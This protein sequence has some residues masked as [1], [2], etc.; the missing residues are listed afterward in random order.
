MTPLIST[1]PTSSLL[2][3]SFT[4]PQIDPNSELEG[5]WLGVVVMPKGLAVP[6]GELA[7]VGCKLG[8]EFGG[9]VGC[10]VGSGVG[11]G[12]GPG[13]GRGVRPRVG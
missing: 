2:M 7:G 1:S 4:F 3:S 5:T 8:V 10:G 11:R 6:K 9:D 13:V 12:V